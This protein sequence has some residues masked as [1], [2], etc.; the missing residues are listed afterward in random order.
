MTTS[1]QRNVLNNISPPV[2]PGV[3]LG[4]SVALTL[5][6]KVDLKRAHMCFLLDHAAFSGRS[7][8]TD[9]GRFQA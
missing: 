6:A 2:A 9:P 8:E 5:S 4:E 7:E 3:I 1:N